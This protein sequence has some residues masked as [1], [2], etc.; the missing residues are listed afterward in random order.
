VQD[1]VRLEARGTP[2]ALICT[3]SFLTEARQVA[4]LLGLSHL[5][6]VEIPH[7]LST[8]GDGEIFQRAQHAFPMIEKVLTQPLE[9]P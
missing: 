3:D 8:L 1:A 7:P 2:T 5:P 4:G 9:E 6:I